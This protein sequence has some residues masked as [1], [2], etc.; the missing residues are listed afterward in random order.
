VPLA[1]SEC[2]VVC[3]G[4]VA[5]STDRV[6][7]CNWKDDEFRPRRSNHGRQIWLGVVSTIYYTVQV[8]RS[9]QSLW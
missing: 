9:G 7:G 4:H 5:G 3:S 1:I 6:N 2:V 8:R